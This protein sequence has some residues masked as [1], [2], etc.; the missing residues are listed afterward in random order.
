MKKISIV[1]QVLAFIGFA[2]NIANGQIVITPMP[3]VTSE[4]LVEKLVGEGY[5]FSNV[6]YTGAIQASG[7][8]TN[9]ST[10][11]LGFE[12]GVFLTSGSGLVI[13]GPNQSSAAGASNL[14]PGDSLLTSITTGTTYDAAILEF[15]ILSESD[16]L[17]INYVFGGEDYNEWVGSSFND[18]MGVFVSGLNPMGGEYIHENIAIV[19]GTTGTSVNINGINNGYASPGVIPDGPCMNCEF[20]ADNTGGLTLEYDGL[21]TVLTGWLLVVPCEE[22]HI[23]IGIA[24]CGDGIYD[25]GVFIAEHSISSAPGISVTEILYP[26]N[27]TDHMVEGHVEADV[28][29]KLPSAEYAPVTICF[30]ISGTAINGIDYEE[31]DNCITFEEGQDSVVMHV[32]PLQDGVIEGDE[33]IM[34]IIENTLGCEIKY[35]TVE[36]IIEDY[37]EMV[38]QTSNGA[39]VCSGQS[40][41]FWVKVFNGFPPYTFEW[42]PGGYANDTI[43]VSP[44]QTTTYT[45]TYSDILGAMGTDSTTLFVFPDN[46]NDMTAFSFEME[47]NPE[48]PWDVIGEINE[49]SVIVA[50]PPGPA[51][52]N[53]IASF[54]I[55]NCATAYING[56]EQV[57]GITPNDFSDLVVY[58]VMAQ[59]VD[60][61]EWTV[62]VTMETGVKENIS[63]G[64]S[65]FPNPSE[66]KFY[67]S[68]ETL[69]EIRIIDLAGKIIFESSNEMTSKTEIDLKDQPKGMYFIRIKAGE[70]V[71]N[72]KV[73]IQ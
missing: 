57:S 42:Q 28:V 56:T 70:L 27:L 30:E 69:Y 71:M 36:V 48:L 3:A 31:L 61:Q 4:E 21:T 63:E 35:D 10:T 60:I 19:P 66:G 20:F 45:V 26:P 7:I 17:K 1:I 65:L 18:V 72:R 47:N 12:S 29:F 37:V 6:Q 64:W 9:G 38:S 39:V 52:D 54:T 68:S 2:E 50:L 67:I 15:D 23:K 44:E 24:D 22:Y 51:I 33:T 14:M 11:N 49:D 53:L 62:V 34:L 73:I 55:S 43:V 16:T 25:A 46:Q 40:V 8:F 13:P 41:E 32:T 59:N 5:Q 58:Q